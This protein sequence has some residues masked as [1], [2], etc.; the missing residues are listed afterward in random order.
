MFFQSRKWVDVFSLQK[1]LGLNTTTASFRDM[2]VVQGGNQDIIQINILEETLQG[3][4]YRQRKGTLDIL[5][6]GL[7]MGKLWDLTLEWCAQSPS[8]SFIIRWRR[9]LCRRSDEI[10]RDEID[11]GGTGVGWTDRV[12]QPWRIMRRSIREVTHSDYRVRPG[13]NDYGLDI[14]TRNGDLV[15]RKEFLEV[16][17]FRV[18]KPFLYS[19]MGTEEEIPEQLRGRIA[20]DNLD[21]NFE[22]RFEELPNIVHPFRVCRGTLK[23]RE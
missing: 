9:D 23:Y 21:V 19:D 15:E 1:L 14:M 8:H 5:P 13:W 7:R 17:L 6:G 20:K 10:E 4:G 2:L 12:L 3:G 18:M 11:R 16:V 22:Q